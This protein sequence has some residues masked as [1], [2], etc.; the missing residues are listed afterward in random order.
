ML[1]V[2]FLSSLQKI[3]STRNE[4]SPVGLMHFPVIQ[5]LLTQ[6][7]IFDGLTC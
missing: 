6:E 7:D 2:I 1:I 4:N 3:L 5:I